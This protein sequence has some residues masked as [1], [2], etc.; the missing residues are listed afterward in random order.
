MK[1]FPNGDWK[2][3][4]PFVL[5]TNDCLGDINTILCPVLGLSQQCTLHSL[6]GARIVSC[7]E[8]TPESNEIFLVPENH[9]FIL[10]T[11]GAGYTLEMGHVSVIKDKPVV[12][13][14]ISD[15]P[16][17][18][19]AI[20]ALSK[21][22][23]SDLLR[24]ASSEAKLHNCKATTVNSANKAVVEEKNVCRTAFDTNSALATT[25]KKRLFELLGIFPL[26]DSFSE[27]FQISRYKPGGAHSFHVDW[28]EPVVTTSEHNY[29][30]AGNG[31]NRFVSVYIYL[32]EPE[33]G[34]ETAFNSLIGRTVHSYY[35]ES[36]L[37][38][39]LRCERGRDAIE[40]YYKNYSTADI[41]P[42]AP[43]KV[44][45]VNTAV[46]KFMNKNNLSSTFPKDS[47]QKNM[48]TTC[49]T[50]LSIKPSAL[51][52][53]IVYSQTADG[54][55]DRI[56]SHGGCPVILGEKW[57]ASF[58]VWNGPRKGYWVHNT[59][60][61]VLEKPKPLAISASFESTDVYGAMLYWES[62][63]WEELTPG[64]PVK[65]NTY[66]GHTWR[67]KLNDEVIASWK[68]EATEVN[69][70]FFIS[71]SDLPE[72]FSFKLFTREGKEERRMEFL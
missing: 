64:R 70:K 68:I 28:I 54:R 40:K 6:W 1:L 48:I 38:G 52:M 42:Y 31:T 53:L 34:G 3:A 7:G 45:D 36:C 66:P 51:E 17:I 58:Y 67:V 50:R 26:D 11:K 24:Y 55:V 12:V 8:I 16:R 15:N 33:L 49:R 32:N 37:P 2:S 23:A 25:L 43:P 47:W 5:T 21:K 57:V 20:N 59:V 56:T 13:Q 72:I 44:Q 63:I 10:P 19:R 41:T 4:T 9:L 62:S 27:G 14:T 60:K 35:H 39:E 71:S 22:E 61:N 69:Q 46:T 18:F 65:V 30:S 29:D